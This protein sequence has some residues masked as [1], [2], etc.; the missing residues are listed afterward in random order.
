MTLG[1]LF[2]RE[3]FFLRKSFFSKKEGKL[4]IAL[5]FLVSLPIALVVN[6][7]YGG[8]FLNP[9]TNATVAIKNYV[10]SVHTANDNGTCSD[11]WDYTGAPITG[12]T[13]GRRICGNNPNGTNTY[14]TCT[15]HDWGPAEGTCPDS[16]GGGTSCPSA[17]DITRG[18]VTGTVG[19]KICGN[20]NNGT[21]QYTCDTLGRWNEGSPT[22][23]CDGGGG[24]GGGTCGGQTCSANYSCMGA[25]SYVSQNHDAC[26]QNGTVVGVGGSCGGQDGKPVN[27]L[28]ETGYCSA[29]VLNT[30]THQPSCQNP[31]GGNCDTSCDPTK[32]QCP[33]LNFVLGDIPGNPKPATDKD[34]CEAICNADTSP[35][36]GC[37]VW[38]FI[39]AA[40]GGGSCYL[41]NNYTTIDGHYA[42]PTCYQTAWSGPKTGGGTPGGSCPTDNVYDCAGKQITSGTARFCGNAPTAGDT[43]KYWY[44]C[45][46]GTW[47]PPQGDGVC[48]CGGGGGGTG[49]G[50]GG[51]GGGGTGGGGGGGGGGGASCQTAG[52]TNCAG[53]PITSGTGSFCGY[54]GPGVSTP[55]YKTYTCSNG[56]WT[57][58]AN[59]TDCNAVGGGGAYTLTLTFDKQSY[60]QGDKGTLCY[61][62]APVPKNGFDFALSQSRDNSNF[63]K[64]GNWH[65]DGTGDCIALTIDPAVKVGA[66]QMKIDASKIDGGSGTTSQT[67]TTNITAGTGGGGG[68]NGG[69]GNGGG[70]GG[71]GNGGGGAT[72]NPTGVSV[73]NPT[74]TPIPGATATPIPNATA[75]PIPGATATPI[76][77]TTATPGAGGT[78]AMTIT[79]DGVGVN[80]AQGLNNNPSPNT[81]SVEINIFD[82]SG[83]QT[84]NASGTLTY[85]AAAGA[86]KGNI[87][88]TVAAGAYSVKARFDNSLWKSINAVTVTA[89]ATS[90]LPSTKLITG[91]LNQDNQLDLLDYNAMLAAFNQPVKTS[92]AKTAASVANQ[93]ADLNMDGVVDEL[94]LNI[95]YSAFSHRQGD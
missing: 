88:V 61:K 94:D 21:I 37:Q 69:G 74:A 85:D 19:D 93:K 95:L 43:K 4:F 2:R 78:L 51:G 28:C 9:R 83:A 58:G 46:S 73:G 54:S 36:G 56:T 26:V 70:G 45:T 31:A 57:P 17:Y 91:D 59:C 27:A 52:V 81:R 66:L 84:S 38:T 71:G 92:H 24:G 90:T 82:T 22:V 75:T 72:P 68:G 6:D 77:G 86:F 3:K 10:T 80:T 32:K 48:T 60:A 62:M 7:T 76:P 47:G 23:P 40:S 8:T 30:S 65:D 67:A 14:Y 5:L 55:P 18:W 39:G 64:L 53:K 11:T 44:N 87:P 79:I 29:T 34:N 15:D 50:G 12:A 33:G 89:G 41:K 25:A 49:G 42:A 16:G 63:T 20:S 35:Q 13:P 1:Q